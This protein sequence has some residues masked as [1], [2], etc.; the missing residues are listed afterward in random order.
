MT[1]VKII[2]S[3]RELYDMLA[4]WL[5]DEGA[6]VTDS[7]TAE[8]VILDT[9]TASSASA[10]HVLTVGGEDAELPRPF[11][12]LTFTDAVREKLTDRKVRFRVDANRRR[13]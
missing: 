6:D 4:L 9:E 8:L 11:S 12:R 7:P 3:D 13:I 5:G 10:K 2:T 1:T